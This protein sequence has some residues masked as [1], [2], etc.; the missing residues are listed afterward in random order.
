M[1]T[2]T[3]VQIRGSADSIFRYASQVEHWPRILPH[4]RRV[5]VLAAEGA[6]RIVEMKARR[7]WIPMWWCAQQVL[8]PEARRIRFTHL[9][10]ITRGMEVEWRLEPAAGGEVAVSIVH[11]LR[12]GWPLIGAVVARSIIGPMFV[13]PTARATLGHIKRLVEAE[14]AEP[15]GG[16]HQRKPALGG[17]V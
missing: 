10:G 12:L 17:T 16:P 13:E 9:R 6:A 14:T 3:A 11:D 8:L 15:A 5:R 4:Y 7:G 1:H 2:E